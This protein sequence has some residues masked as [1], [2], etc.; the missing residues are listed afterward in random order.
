[1]RGI[2]FE[3]TNVNINDYLP[4]N[5]GKE[6]FPNLYDKNNVSAII[7]TGWTDRTNNHYLEIYKDKKFEIHDN[8]LF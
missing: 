4:L 5:I 8:N 3:K 1:M 2:C 6:D 7:F